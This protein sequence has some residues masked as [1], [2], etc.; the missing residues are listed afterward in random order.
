MDTSSG[1]EFWVN[2]KG[3]IRLF[4]VVEADKTKAQQILHRRFPGIEF[5]TWQP[6]PSGLITMLKLPAGE[7]LEWTPHN[8]WSAR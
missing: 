3:R 5:A 2:D 1:T 7:V 8:Q 6:L 4:T